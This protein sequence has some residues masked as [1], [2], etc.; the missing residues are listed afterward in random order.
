MKAGRL[1]VSMVEWLAEMMALM[2][3]AMKAEL[4]AEWMAVPTGKMMVG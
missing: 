2:K 1:V 4:L 3:V